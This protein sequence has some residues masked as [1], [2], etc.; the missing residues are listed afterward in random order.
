[1]SEHR[2]SAEIPT[3]AKPGL[4]WATRPTIHIRSCIAVNLSDLAHSSRLNAL[5]QASDADCLKSRFL[6]L[7]IQGNGQLLQN[8]DTAH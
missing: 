7:T 4:E 1:M 5:L 8:R 3:Q 2:Q 6:P